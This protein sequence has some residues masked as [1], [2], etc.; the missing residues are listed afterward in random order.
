MLKPSESFSE[1]AQPASNT[2]EIISTIQAIT[3]SSFRYDRTRIEDARTD[4][5]LDRFSARADLPGP[6]ARA[7]KYPGQP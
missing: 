4:R 5:G 2:P 7:G 1:I 6:G 3:T